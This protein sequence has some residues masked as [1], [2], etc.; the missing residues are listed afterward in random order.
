MARTATDYTDIPT[1]GTQIQ[2]GAA[3][4]GSLLK[5]KISVIIMRADPGNTGNV[6][7]GDSGVS[8]TNGFILQPG[9]SFEAEYGTGSE[10]LGYWWGD[11]A[12]N[13]DNIVWSAILQ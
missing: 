2:L 13:G 9:E 11:A 12:T 7:V 10:E 5:R 1:A 8:L 4:A 3:I 6:A